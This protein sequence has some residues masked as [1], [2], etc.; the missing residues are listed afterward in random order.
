MSL[1]IFDKDKTLLLPRPNPLH[2]PLNPRTP[3]EQKV[4]P[5]VVEKLADLR[6]QGHSIAIASNQTMVARGMITYQQAVELMEDCSQKI[7]GC[8]SWKFSP[9]EPI[10]KLIFWNRNPY[11]RDDESHKPHP[12]MIFEIM[13]E[14][15]YSPEQTVMIG[16]K[17][18]DQKAAMGAGAGFIPVED[19]FEEVRRSKEAITLRSGRYWALIGALSLSAILLVSIGSL[20]AQQMKD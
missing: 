17:K 14:L 19:F 18:T 8:S 5:G 6:R 7:G 11:Q 4:R 16:D 12:G 2:L 15:G 13:N 10:S 20:V 9:Y 3:S 1:Y